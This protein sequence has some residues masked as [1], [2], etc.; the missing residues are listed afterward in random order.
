M[1]AGTAPGRAGEA[2]SGSRKKTW[3]SVAPAQPD[4]ADAAVVAAGAARSAHWLNPWISMG[5]LLL[6][7]F[8][9]T[10]EMSCI[11]RP[12]ASRLSCSSSLG[13]LLARS[14]AGPAR[15]SP[16][17]WMTAARTGRIR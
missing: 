13:R 2:A 5:R 17:G 14:P 11:T 16:A 8:C 12:S 15:P 1:A 7:R 3:S 10:V 4:V 9:G 6:R